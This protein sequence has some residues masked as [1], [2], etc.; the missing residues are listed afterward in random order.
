VS[1]WLGKRPVAI[2]IAWVKLDCEVVA[3][4]VLTSALHVVTGT[5]IIN[6]YQTH[7]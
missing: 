5:D 6:D 2:S 3:T 7:F 4:F 1:R